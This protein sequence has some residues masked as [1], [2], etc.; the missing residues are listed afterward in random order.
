MLLAMYMHMYMPIS[1][2]MSI[3]MYVYMYTLIYMYL[4]APS[5]S[6]IA[7]QKCMHQRAPPL[8]GIIPL[9]MLTD[10]MRSPRNPPATI[11]GRPTSPNAFDRLVARRPPE[12]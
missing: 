2:P 3:C 7:P 5:L 1:K 9:P 8:R 4:G 6:T 10:E 12:Q 11:I